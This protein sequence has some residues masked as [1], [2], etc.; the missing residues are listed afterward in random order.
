MKGIATKKHAAYIKL[1][2]HKIQNP[3]A[4]VMYGGHAVEIDEGDAGVALARAAID[5]GHIEGEMALAAV[6]AAD[7]RDQEGAA[8]VRGAILG[9]AAVDLDAGEE[10]RLD[11]EFFDEQ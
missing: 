9:P 2:I 1:L 5:M 6:A 11:E 10:Q 4:V 3:S 8:P 7:G